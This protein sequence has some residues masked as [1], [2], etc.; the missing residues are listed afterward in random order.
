VTKR[1]IPKWRR[2]GTSIGFSPTSI[3]RRGPHL[4]FATPPTAPSPT[5]PDEAVRQQSP[6]G[7]AGPERPPGRFRCMGEGQTW[8]GQGAWSLRKSIRFFD[9]PSCCLPR[10]LSGWLGR[11]FGAIARAG[12]SEVQQQMWEKCFQCQ[13][14]R[15]SKHALAES[16][17]QPQVAPSP[18]ARRPIDRRVQTPP[19]AIGGT[20]WSVLGSRP[21]LLLDAPA[22]PLEQ[23]PI[24]PP[25]LA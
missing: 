7:L 1:S 18:L 3:G 21:R 12:Q 6:W 16:P 8:S 14:Q 10:T 20:N 4:A 17:R 22:D 23:S 5:F 11:R 19:S 2:R 15:P 13:L 9:V 25:S 24:E